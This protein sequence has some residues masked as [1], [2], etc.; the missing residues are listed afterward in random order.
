[1]PAWPGGHCP[2]CGDEM[3]PLMVHC[4]T[5]R[6]LLNDELEEDTVVEPVFVPLQE[7]AAVSVAEPR[8][9]YEQCPAC[10][11]ELRISRRYAGRV[12]RC[13]HCDAGFTLSRDMAPKRGRTAY[14]SDCPHCRRELRVGTKYL[15]QQVACKHCGG[16]MQFGA[17]DAQPSS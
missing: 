2:D 17:R 14:Y 3:P 11:R 8:G 13:K 4:R 15:G 12:V 9:V 7:L 1:M 10:G 5:C 6:R 16:Q